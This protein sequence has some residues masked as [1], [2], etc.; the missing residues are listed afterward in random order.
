MCSTRENIKFV[1]TVSGNDEKDV[2]TVKTVWKVVGVQVEEEH[3]SNGQR[4]KQ[5][6][7]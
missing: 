7:V 4:A 5:L 1:R 3:C 6:N 2:H